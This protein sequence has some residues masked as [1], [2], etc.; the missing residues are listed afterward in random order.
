MWVFRGKRRDKLDCIAGVPLASVQTFELGT[1]EEWFQDLAQAQWRRT[2]SA[3][4]WWVIVAPTFGYGVVPVAESGGAKAPIA[5]LHGL[6]TRRFIIEA[7]EMQQRWKEK[8]EA[9]GGQPTAA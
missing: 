1:A 9:E 7:P 3:P 4:N 2:V 5:A 8:L 6:L